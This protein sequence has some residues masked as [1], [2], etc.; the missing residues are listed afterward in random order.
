M[1]ASR[2]DLR[3][4]DLPSGGHSIGEVVLSS[5]SLVHSFHVKESS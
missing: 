4:A 1:T 3:Q 2:F 5:K